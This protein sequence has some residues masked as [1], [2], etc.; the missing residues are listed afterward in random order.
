MDIIRK[1]LIINCPITFDDVTHAE[2]IYGKD[3]A[4]LKGK[5]TASVANDH[6]PNQPPIV[7]PPDI[8]ENHGQVTLCCDIF[9]VLGLP[10]SL[11]VSRNVHFLS[12]CSIPN[13]EKPV[14]RSCISSDVA[15]YQERGFEVT[16]I[17]CDGEY[18]HIK[19][20]FPTI[21]F[22]IC[23]PKD[24]VPEVERAIRTM[25]DTIR[26]TIHGMPYHRLPRTMV[27][28]LASMAAHTLNSFPHQDGISDTLSPAN[29]VTG[30]PKPDYKTLPLEFGTYVQV[31]DGTSSDTKS[32]TL[33]AI[34]TNP[35]GTSS[36]DHFFMSLET[37]LRI[38]RRSWTVLP[39][40]DAT[41]SRVETLAA[42]E[43]MPPVD[44]D[45][46]INE[47]DP[48]E[49]IDESAY[50]RNYLP[51]ASDLPDDHN[52]TTGAFTSES[53][54][55][56]DPDDDDFDNIGHND[57][58]DSVPHTTTAPKAVPTPPIEEHTS[59]ENEERKSATNEE[60]E[61]TYPPPVP[62]DGE[63]EERKEPT[64]LSTPP[65]ID[66]NEEREAAARKAAL[67]STLREK[68]KN[69]RNK[70]GRADYTHRF[71][72][73]RIAHSLATAAATLEPT[74]ESE[75]TYLPAVQKAIYGLIFTQ[76]TAQKGIKKHGQAAFDALRKEFEQFRAMDVLEPLN[77]FELTDE[78]KSESLRALS[79]IKEKRDGRLKGRTV[80]DG[81]AQKGK[82]SK[83]ETGSPTAASD[84][85]LLTTM[86]DAYENRDAAVADVTGAYLT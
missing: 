6:V 8:L 83:S 36:S 76:M 63:N 82:F 46:S 28:E 41:I 67:Q 22:D 66:E 81:S 50:D 2:R 68:R 23:A 44:H 75:L 40:S 21:R 31:Y 62:L 5:T 79:V 58:Y 70:S 43:G 64:I 54:P 52:L 9:Y 65:P 39:I 45:V 27:K 20:L 61:I 60:R 10:F 56:S 1:N 57:D 77:S 73:T 86:I 71:G 59:A 13:R 85:V 7:L 34:A 78:Q 18:N 30:A 37:G 35:T 26:S 80:A 14:I 16:N 47:Y 3:V 32:R 51:P 17:H 49:I 69:L 24:H 53:D 25:K 42:H 48:D 84:V 29:I 11:S 15:T 74:S 72:F 12:C 33:G 55:E 4:F 38:H 19:P